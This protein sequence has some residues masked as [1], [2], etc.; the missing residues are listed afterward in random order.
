[1]KKYNSI[2]LIQ[3]L[4]RPPTV[5]GLTYN[6]FAL[7]CVFSTLITFT[8]KLYILSFSMTVT[9]YIVGRWL[10]AHDQHWLEGFFILRQRCKNQKNQIYWRCRSYAPW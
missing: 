9:L 5:L 3:I 4:T 6:Y 7:L 2:P 10:A 8:T 1:M